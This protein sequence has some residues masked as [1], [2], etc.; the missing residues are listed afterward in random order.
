MVGIEKLLLNMV[1]IMI[2]IL[3]YQIFFMGDHR[4]PIHPKPM[5]IAFCFSLSILLCMTFPFQVIPGFIFDLRTIPFILAFLYGG[6]KAGLIAAF[7]LYAYRT[8]LGGEG[9]WNVYVVYS[10]ILILSAWMSLE[11][12]TYSKR[13]RYAGTI[14]LSVLTSLLM[15]LNTSILGQFPEGVGLALV[16]YVILHAVT[17]GLTVHII[18]LL[19][20]LRGLQEDSIQNEKKKL[21]S[22]LSITIAREI[23]HPLSSVKRTIENLG[24]E[25]F[26]GNRNSYLLQ[27]L[28]EIQKAEQ[29]IQQYLCLADDENEQGGQTSFHVGERIRSA[30][31]SMGSYASSRNV[32]IRDTI[33][34]SI[35]IQSHPNQ[36]TQLLVNFI[37]NGIDHMPS[38]GLLD[39][40]ALKMGNELIIHIS[41]TGDGLSEDQ[42]KKLGT[43]YVDKAPETSNLDMLISYKIVE[44]LHGKVEVRSQKGKGTHFSIIIPLNPTMIQEEYLVLS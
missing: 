22:E 32:Q 43:L 1:F 40:K 12:K 34:D 37:K 35:V 27:S 38:G 3:C 15:I 21:I 41:D 19:H 36:F 14:S 39:V 11:Y 6:Y 44:L 10:F 17:M 8:L 24:H 28:Q 13:M 23:S 4:R 16:G 26:E 7:T 2:P 42:I 20:V 9:V 30:V 33:Q 31:Q 5:V 25:D 18:E 29:A